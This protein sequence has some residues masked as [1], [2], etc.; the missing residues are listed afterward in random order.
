MASS[1]VRVREDLADGLRSHPS[2]ASISESESVN[3]S[4]PPRSCTHDAATR[5]SGDSDVDPSS[6]NPPTEGGSSIRPTEA[7][8]DVT[9]SVDACISRG[10][11]AQSTA[12]SPVD[13]SG[14]DSTPADAGETSYRDT[15][16]VGSETVESI[17]SEEESPIHNING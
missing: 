6:E 16:D 3:F 5:T 8:T 4:S 9:P 13:N 17:Y 14:T 7:G 10:D 12:T 1:P 11:S 2:A 15:H